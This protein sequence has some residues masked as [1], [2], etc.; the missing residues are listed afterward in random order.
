MRTTL[1]LPVHTLVLTLVGCGLWLGTARG[2]ELAWGFKSHRRAGR[3]TAAPEA[4][5]RITVVKGWGEDQERAKFHAATKVRAQVEQYLRSQAPGL[6]WIPPL[7]YI[8]RHL[9]KDPP[10]RRPEKD[11]AEEDGRPVRCWEWTVAISQQDWNDIL[12]HDNDR[13]VHHRLGLLGRILAAVVALL[14]VVTGYI[15]LDDWTKGY[16][17]GWLLAGAAGGLALVGTALWFLS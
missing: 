15:R 8:E 6:E 13:R 4:V 14:A 12:R 7:A 10:E 2:Q 5:K 9:L 1:T 3:T 17:T 11:T 16:Y